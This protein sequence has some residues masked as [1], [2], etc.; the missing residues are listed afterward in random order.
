MEV[1]ESARA[2][3]SFVVKYILMVFLGALVA[4]LLYQ[5]RLIM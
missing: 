2:L 4:M 3:M 5:P 1:E